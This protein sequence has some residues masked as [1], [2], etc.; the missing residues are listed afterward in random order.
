MTYS[1]VDY[2]YPDS[3]FQKQWLFRG[4]FKDTPSDIPELNLGVVV[5]KGEDQLLE[6]M[7]VKSMIEIIN[8]I[9]RRR[10]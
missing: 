3:V 5:R 4:V 10:M 7:K 8:E 9:R 2:N 6:D 1:I